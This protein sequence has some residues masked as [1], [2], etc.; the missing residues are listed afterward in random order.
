MSIFCIYFLFFF[1]TLVFYNKLLRFSSVV[2]SY[3][4][5][6]PF[7]SQLSR[8]PFSSVTETNENI[9]SSAVKPPCQK[10]AALAAN[11]L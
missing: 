6:L 4:R 3:F 10:L 7:L 9:V 8:M 2:I 11:S 1:Y 5:A